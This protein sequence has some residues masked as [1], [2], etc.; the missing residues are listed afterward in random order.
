[1]SAEKEKEKEAKLVEQATRAIVHLRAQ[2]REKRLGLIFGAGI[3]IDLGY[4]RWEALV[5]NIAKRAEVGADDIWDRLK[6]KGPDGRPI[7]RSL[8]SVTQMLFSKFR[9]RRMTELQLEQSLTFIQERSI[10]TDWLRLLHEE[11]YQNNSAAERKEKLLAHPY[12]N[13]FTKIIK[14]SPLTVTYNFDDSIEQM[15]ALARSA[16]E[17]ETTRGYEMIDRPNSHCRRSDS[18]IYHPNG[19]LP[20]VF[21]NGA[22]ADVVFADDFF[23]IS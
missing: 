21:E 1:M 22:S 9:A 3:S 6:A 10:K 4:P 8:S 18:V 2:H 19:F 17:A 11:I 7:T 16:D 13:A 20:A 23:R 14:P 5:Q 15:L 12:L